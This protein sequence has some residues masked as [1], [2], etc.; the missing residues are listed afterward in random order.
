MKRNV[1]FVVDEREMGGVSVVLNDLIHL[2]NR[3]E[4]QIDVLI[5]HDKGSMLK[6]LPKD[7]HVYYGSPYFEAI[8]YT[9]KEAIQS[10]SVKTLLRKLKVI[11]DLKTGRIKKVI[12]KERKKFMHKSYDVEVAYKDGFIAI[13]TAYGDTP[14]KIH[15]LHSAYG[16]FNPTEKYQ[17]LFEE[18]LPKFDHIVGVATNVVK[19]FNEIYHLDN[20]TEV[21]PIAMDTKRI[22]QL[23][24]AQ[25]KVAIQNEDIN[26]VVVGR[27]HPVKGYGRMVDVFARL[28]KEKLLNQ[29]KVHVFGDGPL[30]DNVGKQIHDLNLQDVIY[31]E[32]NIDN[33]YAEMKQ[34]DFLL[35]PSYSEAFGTVISES[36]I[37]HV[38]VLAT[39]TSASQMSVKPNV[40]GWICENSEEGL[41]RQLKDVLMHPEKISTCKKSLNDYEYDNSKI[42][43]RINE[44]LKE[45]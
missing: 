19:E 21:I 7:V 24:S 15:W 9:L 26:I 35:L 2:L 13:F 44:I 10:K 14:K 29:V 23:A 27:A 1:L 30:F 28:Q 18:L 40:N 5:L 25:S 32:G 39:D 36:F 11:F 38:P 41:Y 17:K 42:L 12:P 22:K 6:H 4:F 37:L 8:D 16:T 45:G 20:I 43:K 34:Y 3:D 33:P 31:M